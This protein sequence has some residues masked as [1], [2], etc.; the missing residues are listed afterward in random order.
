MTGWT[1]R[2]S[3]TSDDGSSYEVFLIPDYFLQLKHKH[4]WKWAC[5]EFC[6]AS[7]SSRVYW[8]PL[9]W[10]TR[11]RVYGTGDTRPRPVQSLI[12]SSVRST[13]RVCAHFI[14]ILQTHSWF[15][16]SQDQIIKNFHIYFP[17]RT[18]TLWSVVCEC[19]CLCPDS[20]CSETDVQDLSRVDNSVWD[21]C[22]LL[23]PL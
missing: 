11:G 9:W 8:L 12:W 20:C 4:R 6:S 16:T 2:S 23:S 22:G 1:L 5:L 3:I 15:K 19:L 21:K 10:V 17:S 7:P 13:G 14:V 18:G